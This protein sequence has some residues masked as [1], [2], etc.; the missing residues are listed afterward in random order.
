[1]RL[2]PSSCSASITLYRLGPPLR[3]PMHHDIHA[4]VLA[5]MRDTFTCVQPGQTVEQAIT[6]LRR[7]GVGERIVYF[8]VVGAG[9]QLLG[10]VSARRLLT[11]RPDAVIDSIMDRDVIAIPEQAT[12]LDAHDIFHDKR[13]LSLPVVSADRRILGVVDIDRFTEEDFVPDR[14]VDAEAIFETI[15]LRIAQVR[16]ASPFQASLLRFPWLITTIASGFGCALVVKAFQPTLEKSL[17]LAFSLTLVLALGESVSIQSMTVTVQGLRLQE[18]TLR[19]YRRVLRKEVISAILLAMACAVAVGLVMLLWMGPIVETTIVPLSIAFTL[20]LA[21]VYGI[22]VPTL[23]HAV[24]L[25][26]RI[27]AGPITLAL[28]DITAIAIYFLVAS[29]LL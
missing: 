9:R 24:R 25:D 4:S 5:L 26:P 18:P 1:M 15:G 27:A 29:R 23:L 16:V 3:Y 28:T 13:Y 6:D 22:T 14:S 2:T 11:E 21:C 17:I 12:I 20:V 19:W 10:V 7:D 8:Y